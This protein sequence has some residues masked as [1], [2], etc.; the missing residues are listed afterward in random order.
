MSESQITPPMTQY[1]NIDGNGLIRLFVIIADFIS[2]NILLLAFIKS[3]P[4]FVSPVFNESIKLTFFRL[5]VSM[6]IAQFMYST[7]IYFRKVHF[8]AIYKQVL[9]LTFV[10]C[11]I[12]FVSM[13][14]LSNIS[15]IFDFAM[16]FSFSAFV[17]LI[18]SRIIETS[19][20]QAYRK[21]GGNTASVVFVGNDP[22]NANL[23]NNMMKDQATGYRVIGYFADEEMSNVDSEFRHLGTM[24]DLHSMM[25]SSKPVATYNKKELSKQLS[26]DA[27]ICNKEFSLSGIDEI[28]CSLSH[29]QGADITA[30]MEF[31]DKNVIHFYYVPRQFKN[32]QLKFKPITVGGFNIYTN[33][34]E[35]L[36]DMTNYAKK[37]LFDIVFSSIVCLCLLPILPIIAIIIKLQSPGP[38]FFKQKRTG[39]N[40]EIFNCLKFRSMHVNKDADNLQATKNDPRKFPFGNFM[41][42]TNIDELPQFFNVLKGNMSIVGPRPHMLKH[43]EEYSKIIEKYMVRHFCKPGITGYAQVTGF[44]GE[45][46]D[47]W[48]MEERV[49]RDIW[50]I[51]NWSFALDLK[52]IFLTAKSIIIPDKNAY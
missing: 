8:S 12:F 13:K 25:S 14:I 34:I 29:S 19:I 22:A 9:K 4:D 1:K 40:G 46:K 27:Q 20:L 52:I 28:F 51:E 36:T 16:I 37:R 17:T 2:I 41:R 7:I 26:D 11:G 39:M 32:V 31:C 5:N 10:S 45:T 35:P 49:K 43:T 15:I 21:S 18:L 48:Q 50:Y 42:K 44:R 3:T 33:H 47:V 30:I 23:Y 24:S 6:V 38:L